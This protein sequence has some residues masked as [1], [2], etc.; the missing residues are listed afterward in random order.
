MK[1]EDLSAI[2][3][4]FNEEANI[5]RTLDALRWIPC[6]HVVDGGSTD[7]TREICSRFPNVSF[8]RRD[9]DSHSAQWNHAL[10]LV[11]TPWVIYLDA[12]HVLDGAWPGAWVACNGA[13]D[14]YVT[15][16]KYVIFGK[17]LRACLYPPKVT[18]F[19]REKGRFIQ[20]GHTQR[21]I[22]EGRT[23]NFPAV[24][25]HHDEKPLSRWASN[26]IAYAHRETDKILADGG[27]SLS[28]RIRATGW[29]APL[30]IVPYCLFAR[31]LIFEGVRGWNYTFQRLVAEVLIAL[32]IHERK[33]KDGRIAK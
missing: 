1:P 21:L 18:L 24:I 5:A 20:D 7:A 4:T 10:S 13:A 17:P 6:V 8:H 14:G 19:R 31:G 22:V 30:L 3:L 9:F 2:V 11:K 12:D 16:F 32:A 15:A 23:E 33:W 29:L 28:T 27:K 25:F 26:Q